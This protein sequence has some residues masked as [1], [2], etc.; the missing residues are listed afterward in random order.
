MDLAAKYRE[1]LLWRLRNRTR[2]EE[3]NLN[4]A[5]DRLASTPLHL[6]G[7]LRVGDEGKREQE[8][9]AARWAEFESWLSWQA[10]VCD[11]ENGVAASKDLPGG[12]RT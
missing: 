4:G 7:Q 8:A 5:V 10:G 9:S 1:F 6:N 2:Q 11:T 3:A 12:A